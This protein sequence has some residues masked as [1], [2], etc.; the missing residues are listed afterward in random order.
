MMREEWAQA[1]ETGVDF[2]WVSQRYAMKGLMDEFERD[3][4]VMASE[5][6]CHK[7]A[8]LVLPADKPYGICNCKPNN[9]SCIRFEKI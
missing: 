1:E 5:V 6:D 3:T 8:N 2:Y 4:T 7:L 9:F